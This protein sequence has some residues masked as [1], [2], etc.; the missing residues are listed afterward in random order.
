MLNNIQKGK[1]ITL[2][3]E[4]IILSIC[5]KN[6][7][8][9]PLVKQYWH[10]VY[11]VIVKVYKY[12]KRSDYESDIE[13]L[14]MDVFISLLEKNKQKLRQ[15][16]S[17]QGKSL[18]NWIATIAINQTKDF[19]RKQYREPDIVDIT[20]LLDLIDMDSEDKIQKIL[21]NDYLVKLIKKLPDNYRC[22]IELYLE[23]YAIPIIAEK[24]ELT[25]KQ[26]S[27]SKYLAIQLLKEQLKKEYYK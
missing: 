4:R 6:N 17:D 18:G 2:E 22:I 10:L 11:H 26:V 7:D 27:D 13:D 25:K 23:D 21:D 16:K 5:L 20:E 12:S 1:K 3:E 24:L 14:V 19:I 9:E 8:C 15:W